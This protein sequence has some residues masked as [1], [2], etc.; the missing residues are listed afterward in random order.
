MRMQLEAVHFVLNWR[1]AACVRVCVCVCVG[2][3]VRA[4][5]RACVRVRARACVRACVR[6]WVGVCVCVCVGHVQFGCSTAPSFIS[7]GLPTLTYAGW[8]IRFLPGWQRNLHVGG[9]QVLLTPCSPRF[10][11]PSLNKRI[12]YCSG[13]LACYEPC[14]VVSRQGIP[15]GS[16]PRPLFI[17]Y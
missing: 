10:V 17:A 6:G 16:F 5:L 3:S 8:V 13:S 15:K 7:L 1:R 4:C 12:I 2:A 14:P 11:S 9:M